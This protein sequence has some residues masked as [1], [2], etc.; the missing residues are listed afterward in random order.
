VY[1]AFISRQPESKSN[2]D[3]EMLEILM[4]GVGQVREYKPYTSNFQI[5]KGKLQIA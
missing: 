4:P 5:T 2:A 1:S 3:I